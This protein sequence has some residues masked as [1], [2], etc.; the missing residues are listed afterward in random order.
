MSN[1]SDLFPS[2]GAQII[3]QQIF[4]ASGT[5]TKPAGVLPTDTVVVDLWAGGGSG[6]VYY[7][8]TNLNSGAGGSGGAH[9]RVEFL[10][11]DLLASE[12]VT[13]GAGGA[14]VTALAG[15]TTSISGLDGGYSE[16]KSARAY[17]GGGGSANG[18]NNNGSGGGRDGP[19]QHG[20]L[21]ANPLGGDP[22]VLYPLDYSS[23]NF[24][25]TA[26]TAGRWGPGEWGGACAVTSTELRFRAIHGGAAASLNNARFTR[27]SVWGG[28]AGGA[29][30]NNVA[31]TIGGV[32]QFGGDGGTMASAPAT[33]TSNVNG[34]DGEPRGGGG[35]GA[36]KGNTSSGVTS[37]A[38]GRGE[39]VITIIR[40]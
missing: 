26:S 8:G 30:I 21:I 40:R 39:V 11:S 19:G 10:A 33:N 31:Q 37:G 25:G 3:D 27:D 9:N 18:P 34:G 15:S 23:P 16:F 4:T 24:S 5:W 29:H 20:D 7:S 17:G 28:G 12:P 2:S 36:K 14:A 22:Q 32:S 6:A 13:V 38:G 1:L 35:S